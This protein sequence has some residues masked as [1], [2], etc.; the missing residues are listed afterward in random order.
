MI[1]TE[2]VK[3]KCIVT[4]FI[5][6]VKLQMKSQEPKFKNNQIKPDLT[7]IKN[8]FQINNNYL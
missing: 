2:S 6:P 3:L 8:N 5:I 4:Y 7:I 1:R